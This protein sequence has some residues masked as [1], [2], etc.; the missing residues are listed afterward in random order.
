MQ[1]LMFIKTNGHT[2]FQTGLFHRFIHLNLCSMYNSS[3]LI[4]SKNTFQIQKYG[5]AIRSQLRDSSDQY[6]SE[7][8]DCCRALTSDLIQYDDAQVLE[9]QIQH[10][11][12]FTFNIAK[13]SALL[14]LLPN[15]VIVFPSAEEMKRFTNA[16]YLE[17]IDECARKKN[18]YKSLVETEKI[19]TP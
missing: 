12:R 9:R 11:E 16:F 10:L 1:R 18:H 8:N 17:L 4:R 14:P 5:N 6:V 2:S 19:Y 15:E 3:G 13:F 7:L